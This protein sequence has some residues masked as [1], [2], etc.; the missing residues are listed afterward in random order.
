M[1]PRGRHPY[2]KLTDLAVRQ[3]RPGRHADGGGLYLFVRSTLAR[4][5]VQR[6]VI[7]GHRCDLGLGPYP[8]VS[9]AEARRVALDNRRIVRAGG[10]PQLEAARQKGPT[11]RQVYEAA[12]E[13]RRKAWDRKETEAWWC[14]GFDKHVLPKIG[15]KPVAA[16]T[17]ADVRDIVVPHWKGRN[18][19]GYTLRQNIEYV[20]D[21]AVIEKYRLDNPASALKRL[22]PKV[23]KVPNHRPSLPYTE[24]R[25]AMAEWQVLPINPAVKLAVLFI[26]LTGARLTEATDAT[27][28][29]IDR[30]KRVWQVPGRR[31]KMRRGHDVP[32]SWQALEVLGAAAKLEPRDAFIF[33]LRRSNRVARPPSQRTVSDALRRLGRVDSDGRRIVVHGFRSTFRVWAMEC[34]PGSAEVAEIALAHEE[35]DTTKKAYAR[36]EL[37]E[38]RADLL[39]RWSD[40]VLPD[41][42]GDGQ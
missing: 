25:Q 12:T 22:L 17:L 35:S 32:L 10:D 6:I 11:F 31:M 14:R 9:L 4:H 18:S 7:H 26:V 5:W 37:D 42:L 34:V 41:G 33:A 13:M 20:L 15:D 3:A 36:S 1:A 23:R 16:V 21:T 38:Q 30:S 28:S 2:N 39:Q 40:Y 24:V 19:T 27:W 8:L 29:E